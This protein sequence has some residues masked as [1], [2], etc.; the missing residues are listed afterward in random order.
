MRSFLST[1][2]SSRFCRATRSRQTALPPPTAAQKTD[3]YVLRLSALDQ[4]VTRT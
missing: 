3:L 2:R 1:S 4:H